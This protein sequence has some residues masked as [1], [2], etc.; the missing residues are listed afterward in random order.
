MKSSSCD[1]NQECSQDIDTI[2]FC[3]DTFLLTRDGSDPFEHVSQAMTN[4]VICI[5][6]EA[7]L[8][9]KNVVDKAV[10]ITVAEASLQSLPKNI[11]YV[12]IVNNHAADSTDP[13]EL[14]KALIR[15]GKRVIG[16]LNPSR[17]D[18]VVA[19]KTISFFS[20]YL[21]LP[22]GRVS[23]R[24]RIINELFKMIRRSDA[25][26]RIVNLHWGYEHTDVPAP[27]QITLAHK[28]VD[29]GANL[30]IGHHPHVAQGW[31]IYNNTPI[32]YSL[33]NFNFGQF[34]SL[35]QENNCWGYMVSFDCKKNSGFPIPYK[36]NN[37]YQPYCMTE[38]EKETLNRK[39]ETLS[40]KL[41]SVD[42]ADWFLE[43]YKKW[44]LHE[45]HVWKS[46]F[47][48]ERSLFIIL[49]WGAW[50]MLPLQW[51]FYYYFIKN[52]AQKNNGHWHK[53]I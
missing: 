16:P 35:P 29:A 21:K 1:F 36:I 41:K 18:D 26:L 7:S 42:I 8:K 31:E 45:M 2:L 38:A 49:K 32:F 51:C 9:G 34:D 39:V 25:D 17:L 48:R 37:N 40:D 11:W 3:G 14:C 12:S 30:I 4:Y 22:R 27:F 23:Y 13:I 47:L 6:L 43:S 28:I 5:N 33:G 50:L 46:D 44:F 10:A 53:K 20:A 24:G 15:M 52:H 19:G